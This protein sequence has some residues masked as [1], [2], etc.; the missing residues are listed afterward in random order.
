MPSERG[1]STVEWIALVL[2]V[3]LALG[4]LSTL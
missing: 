2:A 1:Q 4:A 3:A